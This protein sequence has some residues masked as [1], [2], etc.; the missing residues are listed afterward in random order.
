MEVDEEKIA[1]IMCIVYPLLF[2]YH[3]VE[4]M[5]NGDSPSVA[6]ADAMSR[7]VRFYPNFSGAVVAVNKQGEHGSY[8]TLFKR[9]LEIKL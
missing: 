4:R 8:F 7:I 6:A 5:R 3:T 1:I 2:S 9:F